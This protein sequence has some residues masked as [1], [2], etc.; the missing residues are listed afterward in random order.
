M[1][2]S[3]GTYFRGSKVDPKSGPKKRGRKSKPPGGNFRWTVSACATKT[4]FTWLGEERRG[5]GAEGGRE[6]GGRVRGRERGREGERTGGS[7]VERRRG[8]ERMGGEGEGGS[9]EMR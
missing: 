5:E 2:Y 1:E 6:G 9:G 4:A 3:W 8:E 7:R